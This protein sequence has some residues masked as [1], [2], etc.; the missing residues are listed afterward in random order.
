[1]AKLA[2]FAKAEREAIQKE[3]SKLEARDADV[4]SLRRV[5]QWRPDSKTSA[6]VGFVLK[7][8]ESR[9]VWLR[10]ALVKQSGGGLGVD[11]LNTLTELPSITGY[12]R[13]GLFQRRLQPGRRTIRYVIV[14]K[15]EDEAYRFQIWLD[16]T[17]LLESQFLERRSKSTGWSSLGGDRQA[18]FPPKQKLPWLFSARVESEPSVGDGFLE[19]EFRPTIWLSAQRSEHFADFPGETTTNE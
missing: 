8:P 18:D 10:Y 6:P 5:P 11:R 9:E 14:P 13:S 4:V 1:M 3:Y 19:S 17:L 7:V 2:E 16:E 12:T 15:E